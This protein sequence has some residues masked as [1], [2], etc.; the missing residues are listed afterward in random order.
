MVAAS[1]TQFGGLEVKSAEHIDELRDSGYCVVLYGPPGVGKTPTAAN[2]VRNAEFGA[3]G[4]MIDCAGGTRSVIHL[5]RAG[6]LSVV[7]PEKWEDILDIVKDIRYKDLS[8]K[9]FVFDNLTEMANMRGQKILRD[10][11]RTKYEIQD[12][13]VITMDVLSL[14]RTCRDASN[15]QK[16][17][18]IFT[19]WEA[20]E[21]D[22][23]TGMVKRDVAFNPALQRQLPGV[24]DVVGH[25]TV[26][27]SDSRRLSFEPTETTASRIRRPDD[28]DPL[29]LIPDNI[30]YSVKEYPIAEMVA[31][32]R[33]G[34]P[35]PAKYKGR[36]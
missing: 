2:V 11:G 7:R 21:K 3:P 31:T 34:V 5:V 30:L 13:N 20:P 1:L 23:A 6:L 28:E 35:F 24:V 4:L 19:C 17:N 14:V 29:L 10:A 32:L 33:G 26:W 15:E 27:D 9:S 25:I 36:K 22:Q 12:W 16:V 18:I 8:Y